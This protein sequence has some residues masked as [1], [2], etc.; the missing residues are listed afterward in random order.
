MLFLTYEPYFQEEC[1]LD[2]SSAIGNKEDDKIECFICYETYDKDHLLILLKD[3]VLLDYK[4]S[5]RCD[6]WIHI[7]CLETWYQYRHRC[8][9]CRKDIERNRFQLDDSIHL[10]K[11][12]YLSFVSFVLYQMYWLFRWFCFLYSIYFFSSLFLSLVS[13]K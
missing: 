8:P 12:I 11:R 2:H 5:C 10:Q 3:T 6:G 9:I 13:H 4:K 7:H 1:S